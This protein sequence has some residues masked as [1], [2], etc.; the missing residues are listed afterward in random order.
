MGEQDEKNG[1]PK[2][3]MMKCMK[4]AR[5]FLLI[6]GVVIALAFLLGYFL[7]PDTVRVLWL[8]ITGTLLL[9]GSTF[10]ILMNLW[11]NKNQRPLA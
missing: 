1:L 10:Y 3:G 4:G 2:K 5:W 7:E 9:L 6:P 8:I 11:L